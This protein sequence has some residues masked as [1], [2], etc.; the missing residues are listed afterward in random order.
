M[1]YVCKCHGY[2]FLKG[3][4]YVFNVAFG[5]L[6]IAM[7]AIGCYLLK[8]H[9]RHLMPDELLHYFVAMACC[10]IVIVALGIYGT[11][12]TDDHHE[13]RS[14]NYSLFTFAVLLCVI[15]AVQCSVLAKTELKVQDLHDCRSVAAN[16]TNIFSMDEFY[17]ECHDTWVTFESDHHCCGLDKLDQYCDK[18][19]TPVP[20]EEGCRGPLLDLID[21]WMTNLLGFAAAIFCIEMIA[22]LAAF[23]LTCC[24]FENHT[25]EGYRS[26]GS[27]YDQTLLGEGFITN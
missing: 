27:S 18:Q 26:D 4:L 24:K 19:P 6:G 14:R 3:Y 9:L 12:Q 23:L 13:I 17:K 22:V 15:A 20:A 16:C 5:L 21:H 1:F 2:K 10:Q 7:L 8:S 25:V 11:R